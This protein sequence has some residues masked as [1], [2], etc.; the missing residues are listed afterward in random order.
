MSEFDSRDGMKD[1]IAALQRRQVQDP[2]KP[3]LALLAEI[4]P[5]TGMTTQELTRGIA[6]ELRLQALE[7]SL[8]LGRL[9]VSHIRELRRIPPERADTIDEA[10]RRAVDG[11]LSVRRLRVLVDDLVRGSVAQG[12]TLREASFREGIDF[13]R[14]AYGFVAV[15]QPLFADARA[16]LMPQ[17]RTAEVAVDFVLRD[18]TGI[19]VAFECKTARKVQPARQFV[20]LVGAHALFARKAGEVFTVFP[21]TDAASPAAY[22]R[23]VE[24]FEVERLHTLILDLADRDHGECRYRIHRRRS[25]GWDESHGTAALALP[26]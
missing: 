18:G 17:P 21:A 22:R 25:D 19:L 20:D 9:T 3:H 12:A 16:M 1:Q 5:A 15:N 24:S 14:D 4:A 10:V 6:V 7:E 26:E 2:S 13:E 8:D 11:S 23:L